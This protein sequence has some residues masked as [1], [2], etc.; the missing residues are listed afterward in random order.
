MINQFREEIEEYLLRGEFNGKTPLRLYEPISYILGLKGK[1]IR[2]LLTMIAYN[3][4][5]GKNP[6]DVI[7]LGCAVE[8]FHNFTLIHDDIMDKAPTRRGEPTVH[9]KWDTNVGILSGDAVFAIS[10]SWLVRE[11]PE[12]A[13]Q[14]V[15]GFTRTALDVCEGQQEDMDMATSD[16]V[17]ID[18]YI[19][20]IRKKTS[21]L[22][23]EALRLGAIAGGAESRLADAFYNY[24]ILAGIAFQLQD[25]FMDAYPPEGFGKQK[26]GDIIE[27]K[28]TY[29]LLKAYEFA[30]EEQKQRLDYW[31]KETDNHKKVEGVLTLFSE[32]GVPEATQEM[33]D[34]YFSLAD[35]MG[36]Q[37]KPLVK[38]FSPLEVMLAQISNR[39]V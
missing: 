32:L 26:G 7:A 34:Y 38:D 31:M 5:S 24:G 28:K 6:R 33:I 27:N 20:M 10:I 35:R 4:V 13:A 30:S 1:R 18:H 39:T 37:I 17:S 14:L 15:S 29:L 25:D 36:T 2:P 11:F 9:E 3:I 21:V 12:K 22:L 19:E 8:L 16:D 23:G